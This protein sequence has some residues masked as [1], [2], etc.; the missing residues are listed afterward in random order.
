MRPA[1]QFTVYSLISTI[2]DRFVTPPPPSTSRHVPPL[3]R[4]CGPLTA[5]F[6]LSPNVVLKERTP[7]RVKFGVIRII[8]T[9]EESLVAAIKAFELGVPAMHRLPIA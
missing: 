5:G 9:Q 8:D 1:R 3:M 2:F 4:E 7:P 6:S